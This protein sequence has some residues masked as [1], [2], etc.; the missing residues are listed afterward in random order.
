V[1]HFTNIDADGTL[2]GNQDFTFIGT[3]GFTAPGQINWFTNITDTFIQ[4]NTDADPAAEG[5]I[6]LMGAPPG[7]SVL[8]FL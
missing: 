2:P 5:V 7:D 8:M 1:L 3:A 4:L 6:Q